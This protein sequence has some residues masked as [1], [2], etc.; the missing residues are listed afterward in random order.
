MVGH[1]N[2][3]LEGLTT[4]RAFNAEKKLRNEFDRH[5]DLYC[6]AMVTLRLALLGFTF[7][8]DMISALFSVVVIAW[9]LFFDQGRL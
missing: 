5:Q 7:Y 1:I 2:A 9:F 4:V 8:M 6:S 3:S